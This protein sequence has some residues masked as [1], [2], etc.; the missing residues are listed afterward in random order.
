[1]V[2]EIALINRRRLLLNGTAL[3]AATMSSIAQR[4][5]AEPAMGSQVPEEVIA[6]LKANAL[7]LASVEP[8]SPFHDLAP[9]R[10]MLSKARVVSLGE[11]THGTREFFKLK[12][13]LIEYCVSELGFTIVAFEANYGSML[14]V[15][16]YVLHGKG[17][18]ADVIAPG[19]G[20]NIY[21]TEEVIALIEWVRS[22]NL[23]HAR[24]V[25]FH[26]FDMQST[27]AATL[28]LLA[29]L[30]R[31][32]PALAATS[33]RILAPL[34]SQFTL[35]ATPLRSS[36]VMRERILHQIKL[37][38]DAFTAE[39]TSWSAHTAASEWH[40]ARQSAVMLAQFIRMIP[41]EDEMAGFAVR[42]RA[43][44]D[45]VAAL[46]EANGPDA[47]ALLWAHNGHVKRSANYDFPMGRFEAPTMG[48]FLHAMFGAEHVVIG[49]AFNRGAY[50]VSID[51]NSNM[52]GRIVGP[53]PAGYVDAVM[54][55]TG[56]PLYALDLT[57]VS[58]EGPVARWMASKPRQ[59]MLGNVLAAPEY[60]TDFASDP[61]DNWD[62]IVFV[63][64]TT[65]ARGN[66]R[67]AKEESKAPRNG[68]PTNLALAGSSGIP[69]GW[70]TIDSGF[71]TADRYV[72]T[73]AL[74]DESSPNGGKT[75]RMA[76]PSSTVPW[77][78]RALGQSFPAAPWRGKRLTFSVAMRADAP[79]IGTGTQILL[80]VFP[81]DEG[82][83]SIVGLQ[84]DGPVRSPRWTRRAVAIDVADD[85]ERIQISLVMTGDGAGFFGDLTLAAD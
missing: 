73:V 51:R 78:D 22:W 48:S 47:K 11:S 77:G 62:V 4:A 68:E 42:D 59:R 52:G 9:L 80:E 55:S 44:A 40:L 12:H 28:H 83:K 69:N 26:G 60:R 74:T 34:A 70:G 41:I 8:G 50:R 72:L 36:A 25:Q 30:E 57:G 84:A 1:L 54:A 79:R 61:R 27:P 24:K 2:R 45:N 38:I 56:I 65:A 18:I 31:V 76:R 49:F 16:D 71:H 7:P 5:H 3:V 10:P 37:A 82:A 43:M 19:V 17:D 15:N 23:T 20:F 46:L 66:S 75:V 81:K 64:S 85:A 35:F 67:S 14:A 53:A 6:W 29:Y 21:D 63:E 58:A 33:E 13:R 32:A 39:R